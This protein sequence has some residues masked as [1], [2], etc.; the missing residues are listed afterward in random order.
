[1]AEFRKNEQAI[2]EAFNEAY[3]TKRVVRMPLNIVVKVAVGAKDVGTLP[4]DTANI[5]T[6]NRMYSGN[7]SRMADAAQEGRANEILVRL[8][9][10]AGQAIT[11]YDIITS[12]GSWEDKVEDSFLWGT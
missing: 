11:G 5:A 4:L 2:D 6:G 8:I 12:E 1:V 7:L 10:V 3:A 9:P